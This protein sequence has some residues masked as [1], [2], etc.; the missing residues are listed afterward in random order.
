M[1]LLPLNQ[2]QDLTEL[3]LLGTTLLRPSQPMIQPL[4]P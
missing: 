4:L 2:L 3:L 1:V